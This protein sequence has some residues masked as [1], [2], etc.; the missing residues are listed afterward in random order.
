MIHNNSIMM[1]VRPVRKNPAIFQKTLYVNDFYA[2]GTAEHPY[3]LGHV[4]LIGKIR[5]EMIAGQ[6]PPT[7]A[8]LRHYLTE[9]GLTWWLF[10][11]DLPDPDNRVTL[12]PSGGIRVSWVP[13]NTR[14][15]DLL[16]RETRRVA[17]AAGF[18]ITFARRAGVD[19]NSHQAGTA[20]MGEDPATSVVDVTCRTHDIANLYVVD[21]SFFPS[22]PVMNPALT[23]MAN[24]LRV[25]DLLRRSL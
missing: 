1:S 18:P 15:H 13:N 6:R 4:Q 7:P 5:K 19:V 16:V 24:A 23:I 8:W 17:R 20:R 14:S 25:G 3:P 10:T 2:K 22:L 9:R 11:E 12:T 21:S